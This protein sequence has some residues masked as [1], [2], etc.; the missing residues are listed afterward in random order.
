MT[1]PG[2]CWIFNTLKV[3]G[4]EGQKIVYTLNG[5]RMEDMMAKQYL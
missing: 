1:C 5:K 3:E 2:L 4:M